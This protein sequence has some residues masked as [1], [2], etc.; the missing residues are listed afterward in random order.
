MNDELMSQR[1]F[2][3]LPEVDLAVSRINVLVKEGRIPLVNGKIPKN[4][5]IEALKS[6]RKM[7]Y[8]AQAKAAKKRFNKDYDDSESDDE[9]APSRSDLKGRYDL[10]KTL[11]REAIAER[12]QLELEVERGNLIHV[13]DVEYE[14][15][16]LAATV[17]QK[18][19][20]I[21]PVIATRAENK[22][23]GNIER[24]VELEINQ[25]M[26]DLQELGKI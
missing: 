4:L 17:R 2:S 10:A 7:G 11:E 12:K 19:L 23:A 13:D 6:T 9:D 3:K 25:A 18:L 21:A 14:A 8:E 16:Q 24:I 5:G 15:G 20:S 1:A 22:D 26:S